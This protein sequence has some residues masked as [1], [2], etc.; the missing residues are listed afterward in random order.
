MSSIYGVA[1]VT[2]LNRA[3]EFSILSHFGDY[4]VLPMNSND[5]TLWNFQPSTSGGAENAYVITLYKPDGSRD[6]NLCLALSP[7]Q[8]NQDMISIVL[9]QLSQP[10][11]PDQMWTLERAIVPPA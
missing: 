11:T 5:D 7:D 3:S 8:S 9:Q 1:K 2:N 6:G 4:A 10:P